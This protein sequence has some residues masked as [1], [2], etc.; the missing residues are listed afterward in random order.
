MELLQ[1]RPTAWEPIYNIK[2]FTN[3]YKLNFRRNNTIKM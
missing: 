3:L 2:S 1:L